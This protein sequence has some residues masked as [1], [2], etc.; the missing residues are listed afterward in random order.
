[1]KIQG[2]VPP[3]ADALEYIIKICQLQ[4]CI[5]GLFATLQW[6]S[7]GGQVRARAPGR[8]PW[9]CISTLFALI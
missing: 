2:A 4:I 1:M 7:K 8:R 5:G 6:R 9:E 3:S